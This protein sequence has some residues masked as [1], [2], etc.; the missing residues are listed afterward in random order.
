MKNS[1]NY[2]VLASFFYGSLLILVLYPKFTTIDNRKIIELTETEA[3][4]GEDKVET[5]EDLSNGIKQTLEWED[6]KGK[7]Y[8]LSISFPYEYLNVKTTERASYQLSYPT[9]EV[10]LYHTVYSQYIT[11]DKVFIDYLTQQFLKLAKK[12]NI[13]SKLELAEMIVTAVQCQDYFLVHNKSC[14]DLLKSVDKKSFDYEYHQQYSNKCVPNAE[15]YGLSCPSEFFFSKK[16]DCDTRTVALF[17][18]LKN[19]GLDVAIINSESH[20]I[21]GIAGLY[22]YEDYYLDDLSSNKKYYLWETTAKGYKIGS[23]NNDEFDKMKASM[24]IALK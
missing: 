11:N 13:S 10:N 17:Q 21:L 16:G 5:E 23:F 4:T 2:F 22:N 1:F 15:N 24:Y 9:D 18:I 19:I 14:N 8:K 3:F 6:F 7:K 20:S 12:A